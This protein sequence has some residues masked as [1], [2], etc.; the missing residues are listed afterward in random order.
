MLNPLLL[1]ATQAR[2]RRIKIPMERWSS[3]APTWKPLWRSGQ[4]D[5]DIIASTV[6]A[7]HG[8]KRI[9]FDDAASRPAC[10]RE[11]SRRFLKGAFAYPFLN[12]D[13]VVLAVADPTRSEAL[14]AIRL[15]FGEDISLAMLS[16]EEIELLFE[17]AMRQPDAEAPGPLASAD[18][19]TLVSR[20]H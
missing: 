20:F 5:G 13:A 4:I 3:K 14:K 17:R 12:E 1:P 18:P 6:A 16:F 10:F 11:L 2:A 19:G 15:A 8:I 7:A 9:S